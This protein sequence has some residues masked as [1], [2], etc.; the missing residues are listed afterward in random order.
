MRILSRIKDRC[1]DGRHDG[2]C[3]ADIVVAAYS[4]DSGGE[5]DKAQIMGICEKYNGGAA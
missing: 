2:V 5:N 1:H 3:D 4:R